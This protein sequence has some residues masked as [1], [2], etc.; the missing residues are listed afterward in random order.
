MRAA[1]PAA[2]ATGNNEVGA[3]SGSTPPPY[4]LFT[5]RGLL[6]VPC[7]WTAGGPLASV[8]SGYKETVETAVGL[9]MAVL[10]KDEFLQ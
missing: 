7:S 2:F 8:C 10:Q 4:P 5:R 1:S 6:N 9:P 3:A